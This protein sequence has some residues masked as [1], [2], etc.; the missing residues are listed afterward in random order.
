MNRVLQSDFLVAR[1]SFASG[2]ARLV[3]F[4]CSFDEYNRSAGPVQADR[5][6]M[7]SDWLNVGYDL[8]DSM[9]ALEDK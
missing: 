8:L 6:A 9:S 3:D 2:V 4:G 5:K 1:P 7:Q